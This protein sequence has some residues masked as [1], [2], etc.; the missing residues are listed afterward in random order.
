MNILL[1]GA[2]G[3][4]GKE[5]ASLLR[6]EGV[7]TP[8]RQTLDITS[9]QKCDF[10]IRGARPSL[11]IHCAA[12]T[13]TWKGEQER[14]LCWQTNV[15]GTRHVADACAAVGARLVYVSTD[16]VFRGDRGGYAVGDKPDPMNFYAES[17]WHGEREAERVANHLIVRTSLR[18]RPWPYTQAP[19]DAFTSGD[20]ADVIAA[21]LLE[22]ARSEKTGIVHQE[23][24]RKSFYELAIRSNP[25]VLPCRRDEM[26][27][28]PAYDLSL[29]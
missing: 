21:L 9:R 4:L 12:Y 10:I 3:R 5:L 25:D 11:V 6:Y 20:Y 23:T 16:S 24:G 29:I 19:T 8:S 1:T 22:L 17:K 28:P 18:P 7:Y 15:D 14:D 13:A 27:Q 2:S 26:S